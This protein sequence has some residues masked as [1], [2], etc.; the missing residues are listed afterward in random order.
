[1]P[2]ASTSLAQEVELFALDG[3]M[4]LRGQLIDFTDQTYTIESS[5]GKL[6]LSSG[7]VL[8]RGEAC[9]AINQAVSEFDIVGIGKLANEV[10]PQFLPSY[11]RSIGAQISDT[12]DGSY[13][14]TN[15][16]NE[17]IATISLADTS[18]SNS[19]PDL[20]SS[21]ATIALT[22]DHL[23]MDEALTLNPENPANQSAD[24]N[25]VIALNA[26]TIITAKDN[27][28]KAI[29][30]S[31]AAKVFS[32]EYDNWSDV[33]GADSPITLYGAQADSEL[34]A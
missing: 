1:M 27:P 10:L 16:E 4:S 6:T 20:L 26:I 17:K 21:P 13:V 2:I 23:L 31:D 11:A 8:C 24:A 22:S 14:F 32:G 34:D 29:S 7:H 25:R 19:L 30:V 5:V 28:L 3:S 33:G 15:S 18:T 12:T 9:P